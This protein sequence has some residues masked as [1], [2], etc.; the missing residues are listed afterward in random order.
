MSSTRTDSQACL[1]LHGSFLLKH[2]APQNNQLDQNTL[3]LYYLKTRG[4]K[5]LKFTEK[6]PSGVNVFYKY[7]FA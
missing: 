1:N 3:Y 4:S 7:L 2:E 6:S 5:I